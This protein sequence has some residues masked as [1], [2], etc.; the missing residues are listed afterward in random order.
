[1]TSDTPQTPNEPPTPQGSESEDP[2]DELVSSVLDGEASPEEE[3]QVRAQSKLF[4]RLSTFSRVAS[5]VGAPVAPLN[6]L[7]ARRML[8]EVMVEVVP[9]EDA[10]AP[11]RNTRSRWQRPWPAL[12]AVA[13]VI[14]IALA[15]PII[16]SLSNSDS[17]KQTTEEA[18]V[19]ADATREAHDSDSAASSVRGRASADGNAEGR[20]FDESDTQA[21]SASAAA[22]S[23]WLGDFD[24]VEGL[25]NEA[26]RVSSLDNSPDASGALA[27]DDDLG[28]AEYGSAN[29]S[30]TPADRRLEEEMAAS[31]P[32]LCPPISLETG[33]TIVE[34]FAGRAQ[35]VDYYVLVTEAAL[36]TRR[37]YFQ[38][39]A[40]C[41]SHEIVP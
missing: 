22:Q 9:G 16:G 12:G 23:T 2:Q 41:E 27:T 25:A 21:P 30:T 24:T 8:D 1:M 14:L 33:E 37:V 15:V 7:S 3:T 40:D 36:Y 10:Q 13:A 31:S 32:A 6:E 4:E 39:W 18:G 38:Q 11:P 35:G 29:P 17:A 19:A 26:L 28:T 5:A 20:A 34:R